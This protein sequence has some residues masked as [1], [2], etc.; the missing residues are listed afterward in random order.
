M[1]QWV[2]LNERSPEPR[3]V[4]LFAAA[5]NYRPVQLYVLAS[6]PGRIKA[7][8]FA[9][10]MAEGREYRAGYWFEVSPPVP[11]GAVRAFD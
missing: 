4:I 3:T 8:D 2:A 9:S 11:A 7:S 10:M 1:S 6:G 5:D